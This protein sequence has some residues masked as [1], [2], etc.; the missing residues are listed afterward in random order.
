MSAGAP[1]AKTKYVS[2]IA[3][4]TGDRAKSLLLLIN[5]AM[6]AVDV[7]GTH[8]DSDVA[9]LRLSGDVIEFDC[10]LGVHGTIYPSFTLDEGSRTHSLT[11]QM[12]TEDSVIRL[13]R[14]C[15]RS[16]SALRVEEDSTLFE[17]EDETF[18]VDPAF[19]EELHE[20]H[21]T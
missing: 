3:D 18:I 2:L 12:Y 4:L 5:H 7:I 9:T 11:G 20:V 10:Y 15:I 8:N 1:I 16:A 13:L 14:T 21:N 6:G 17:P 19:E